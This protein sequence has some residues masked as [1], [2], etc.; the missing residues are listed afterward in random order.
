MSASDK[1]KLRKEERAAVLSEKQRKEQAEAKKL[2]TASV[3]FVVIMIVVA[4]I[5][6]SVMIF[7]VVNSS[8]IIDRNTIAATTGE[9]K[10]NSV[11]L[12]YYYNDLVRSQYNQWQ[13]TYGDSLSMYTQMMGLDITK[14]LDEQVYDE[15][16]GKTWADYFVENAL[17]QARSD[18]KLYDMAMAEG[19]TLSADEQAQIKYDMQTLDFYSQIYGYKKTDDYLKATYGFGSDV[20]SYTEYSTVS[21]IASS[22]YNKYKTDLT[23]THEDIRDHEKDKEV[24]YSSFDFATYYVSTSSFQKGGTKD[25][26]GH[27]VYTDEEKSAAIAEAKAVAEEL[28]KNDSVLTLDKAIKALEINAN[29]ESATSSKYA[30][31]RYTLISEVYRDW[32]AEEGREENDIKVFEN[33]ITSTD[34]HAEEGEET[35]GGYYVVVFQGRDDNMRHLANVRHLLVKFEGG[36]QDEDGHTVYSDAEKAAA[37][38]EAEKFLKEWNDGEATEESFIE[39]VK[40]HSDDGS[41]AE[42][43]LFKDIHKQSDYVPTFRSWAIDETRKAGDTE[44]IESEYGYHVMYYVGDG[45]LTYRDYMIQ[46][47]LRAADTEEWY[48]GLLKD[49]TITKGDISRLATDMIL[50]A[51]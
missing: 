44:V 5:A 12:N 28:A 3:T 35:V 50:A 1:K 8:G 17:E 36:T 16:T 9:H 31:T 30:D 13:S 47:D 29:N 38:E 46:E 2:K 42:G 18:Y 40:E 41:A 19:Y 33:K 24:N 25:E 7:N 32:L 39:L 15:E 37:K 11:Q 48:E 34:P 26:H 22:Y 14:P 27:T 21:T 51:G 45:E 6:A 43:G 20:D 23:Y 49:V 10:I 4:L